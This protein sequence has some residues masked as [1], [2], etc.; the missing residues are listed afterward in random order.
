MCITGSFFFIEPHVAVTT[1]SNLREAR[2][3]DPLE[4]LYPEDYL[5]ANRC[6][7]AAI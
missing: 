7:T 2:N 1:W 3:N 6:S 5:L 4:I